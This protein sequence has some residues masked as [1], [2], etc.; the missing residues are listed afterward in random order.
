KAKIGGDEFVAAAAGVEFPAEGAEFFDESFFD[1]MVDVF[2]VGAGFFEP[3]GIVFCAI[4]DFVEGGEGLLYFGGGEDGDGFE[5]FCP[6]T[7]DGNFV[8]E[9]A[10]IEREGALERVEARVRFAIEAAAPEAIVFAVSHG[11][12]VCRL[13]FAVWEKDTR[14]MRAKTQ[15]L[16]SFGP[17]QLGTSG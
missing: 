4:F 16:R 9:Q 15:R 14:V 6:S 3:G 5:G 7:V 8:G 10:A 1:E 17:E 2:G 13:A 11:R 12:K